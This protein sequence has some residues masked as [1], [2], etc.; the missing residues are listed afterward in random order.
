MASKP[1]PTLLSIQYLR[2]L[3]ALAVAD[4]HIGWSRTEV[5]AAGVDLFFA[6]SGFIMVHI[7]DRHPTPGAFLGARLRRVAPLYWVLTLLTAA[8]HGSGLTHLL[9]SLVVWPHLDPDSG[10]MTVI[11]PGWTLTFEMFF[12]LV[13]AAS[14]WLA[15]RARV[16]A[17]SAVLILLA[18]FT[19]CWPRGTF[20]PAPY[21]IGMLLEFV[22][23]A[24][25][26]LAWRRGWL[27]RG[28]AGLALT[29]LGLGLLLAQWTAPKPEEMRWLLWGGPTLLI[30]AGVLGME[31]GGWLGRLP[32]L[33]A[34]GDAS[35]SIYLTQM[36]ALPLI[37]PAVHA[38]PT[39]LA[40]PLA[41]AGCA[42]VGLACH[43]A[44]EKPLLRWC[45]AAGPP[46]D[47]GPGR[48]PARSASAS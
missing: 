19:A 18:A 28:A 11:P 23:G 44:V 48:R 13:F 26:C 4:T 14:L 30:L 41:I 35:Y 47:Q 10:S 16:P 34:L 45:G 2:G 6:I 27:P 8:I 21:P 24:W 32:L 9:L 1:G 31:A 39:P 29:V 3:A 37:K 40:I 46:A 36:L 38:L 15:P 43:W 5:G 22:G 33:R 20:L 25:I 17:I 42:L 7:A 12:Y